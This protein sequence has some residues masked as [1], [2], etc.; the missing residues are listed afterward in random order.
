M[1]DVLCSKIGGKPIW[2]IPDEIPTQ[3]DV[4]C[5][6]GKQLSFIMQIYCPL[7]E[8]DSAYHRV[9]YVFGCR[10]GYCYMHRENSCVVFRAQLPK[11]NPYVADNSEDSE[12]EI[13]CKTCNFCGMSGRFQCSSCKYVNY[14]SKNHQKKDWDLGHDMICK[15]LK[16]NPVPKGYHLDELFDELPSLE[17][18]V[19]HYKNPPII[20]KEY[21]ITTEITDAP[22]RHDSSSELSDDEEPP[23][24][25]TFE[26][27]RPEDFI[28]G[29]D[30]A[31]L[32]DEEY[33]RFQVTV[34]AYPDQI[35]RYSKDRVNQQPIYLHS[36]NI[37]T[38]IPNCEYC[39][40]TKV[41]ECQLMPQMLFHFKIEKDENPMDWGT[42]LVYTC[43]NNCVTKNYQK[44]TIF[45]QPMSPF[46]EGEE[47]KK[48]NFFN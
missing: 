10:N 26:N 18:A 37:P 17:T 20:L 46:I 4:I 39:G 27:M 25:G 31:E 41:F 32:T 45:V 36:H 19:R 13:L 21:E 35:L 6:C 28:L 38:E 34:E 29:D 16:E 47:P 42:L 8:F 33:V 9:L 30:V 24:D 44:E 14:C 1:G 48:E 22:I 3:E 11:E 40:K 5:G 2:L 23:N 12:V 43:Q 15:V 7:N